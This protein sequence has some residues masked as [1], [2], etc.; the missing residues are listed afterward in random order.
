M[1]R[2]SILDLIRTAIW[3]GEPGGQNVKLAIEAAPRVLSVLEANGVLSVE[4]DEA[5]FCPLC[6]GGSESPSACHNYESPGCQARYS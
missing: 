6:D 2:E 3:P 5:P 1:N 4:E